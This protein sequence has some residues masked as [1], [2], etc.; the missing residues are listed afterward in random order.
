MCSKAKPVMTQGA[1]AATMSN[2]SLLLT[3]RTDAAVISITQHLCA[4][5][6]Q[7]VIVACIACQSIANVAVCGLPCANG[8]HEVVITMK[9]LL[10]INLNGIQQVQ[11]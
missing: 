3:T 7:H 8:A 1:P 4:P 6:I 5:Y 10:L 11:Q 9:V 2:A